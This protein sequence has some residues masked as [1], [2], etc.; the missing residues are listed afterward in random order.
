MEKKMANSSEMRG[1]GFGI[2]NIQRYKEFGISNIQGYKVASKTRNL[3]NKQLPT[4][5]LS[6][7][8]D[9]LSPKDK[10]SASQ[11]N[12]Q[13]NVAA[14]AFD[15]RE[16]EK[17]N[18]FIE[19]IIKTSNQN[20][21]S[22]QIKELEQLV[23]DNKNLDTINLQKIQMIF[24]EKK[25]S[26]L[27]IL[28]TFEE[29][30][31]THLEEAYK[32]E[33]SITYLDFFHLA[34]IYIEIEAKEK[35]R[36]NENDAIF[37]KKVIDEFLEFVEFTKFINKTLSKNNE[38]ELNDLYDVLNKKHLDDNDYLKLNISLYKIKAR[39][40]NL[41]KDTDAEEFR[42]LEESYK[43]LKTC[44]D[45]NFWYCHRFFDL[46]RVFKKSDEP[47]KTTDE[48]NDSLISDCE[49]LVS[50][51]NLFHLAEWV[52]LLSKFN[53]EVVFSTFVKF[54]DKNEVSHAKKLMPVLLSR[55]YKV[56]LRSN[57]TYIN[58]LFGRLFAALVNH[59]QADEALELTKTMSSRTLLPQYISFLSLVHQYLFQ[60]NYDM[61]FFAA[62]QIADSHSAE[63]AAAI[64]Q[65]TLELF[66]VDYDKALAMLSHIKDE[67][68]KY[69][70]CTEMQRVLLNKFEF[71]KASEVH[72]I[73]SSLKFPG[74]PHN[75]NAIPW[76]IVMGRNELN[77]AAYKATKYCFSFFGK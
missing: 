31:L 42:F 25:E 48:I 56:E 47:S 45:R 71:R 64:G 23:S 19:F 5:V 34:R 43:N 29:E 46:F 14:L 74:L 52:G 70:I 15:K 21:Y 61:A 24:N 51:D 7:I 49:N 73:L 50:Q 27:N 77:S 72:D 59:N 20:K 10:Q 75:L 8:F 35:C 11:V 30:D 33:G 68:V 36:P 32:N 37:T 53:D 69:Y 16:L 4:E 28:Q 55:S 3:T 38:K 41:I 2:S 9:L 6:Q 76:A 57:S 22:E 67:N 66:E 54:L 39:I 1:F 58:H 13:W 12:R 62:S 40:F 17:L 65:I 44:H 26:I 18:K 63:E 60:K